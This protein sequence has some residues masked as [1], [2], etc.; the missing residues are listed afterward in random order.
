MQ[1]ACVRACNGLQRLLYD[2]SAWGMH[3]SNHF[4]FNFICDELKLA[5]MHITYRLAYTCSRHECIHAYCKHTHTHTNIHIHLL[6]I[7]LLT[8]TYI[9]VHTYRHIHTHT[10]EWFAVQW[11]SFQLCLYV[12]WLCMCVYVY[13]CVCVCMYALVDRCLKVSVLI[14]GS[15]L[16]LLFCFSQLICCWNAHEAYVHTHTM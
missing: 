2:L 9:H 8:H 4:I 6:I 5:R 11:E 16:V 1:C 14:G 7:M 12:L 10:H 13:V 3:F 15:S